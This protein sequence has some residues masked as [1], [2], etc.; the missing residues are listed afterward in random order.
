MRR[1]TNL[2]ERHRVIGL[3]SCSFLHDTAGCCSKSMSGPLKNSCP[4]TEA[5]E[6]KNAKLKTIFK[7]LVPLAIDKCFANLFLNECVLIWHPVWIL[8]ESCVPQQSPFKQRRVWDAV[9]REWNFKCH[10]CFVAT[11]YTR[12]C[13]P[14]THPLA[15]NDQQ[16]LKW[17]IFMWS[18]ELSTMLPI[19]QIKAKQETNRTNNIYNTKWNHKEWVLLLLNI[20]KTS[21]LLSFVVLS[22][23]KLFTP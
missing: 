21:R 3:S 19:S 17:I 9:H 13:L 6:T 2:E 8:L 15:E 16:F 20:I 11:F 12:S 14:E 23:W 22:C 10:P 18:C 5:I 1:A 7:V 4:A